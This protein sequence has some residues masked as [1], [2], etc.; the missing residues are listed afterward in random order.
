[1]KK[2]LL[3]ILLIVVMLELTLFNVNSYRVLS[4]NSKIEYAKENLEAINTAEDEI[5]IEIDNINTEVKTIH[6]ELNTL[7]NV[8]YQV[9][10]TD[11][12]SSKLKDLPKKKYIM[13]SEKSQYIP[14]YLSGE[15]KIIGIKVFSEL[16]EV[17]KVTI[18]EKIPFE[19]NLARVIVLFGIIT[20]VYLLKTLECYKIPYSIKNFEQELTLI[21]VLCVF[22][23]ITCLIN[24]YSI[25]QYEI[26]YFY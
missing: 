10:Y 14:C 19:F 1:M 20:F 9:F 6:L 21:F 2:K 24:Q 22:V 15:S 8:D 12:T 25:N 11:A 17:E 13:T 4:S 16:A 18:N 3:I 5:Y 26:E 7:E 23:L